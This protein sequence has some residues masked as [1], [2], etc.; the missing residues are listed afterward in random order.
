MTKLQ[1]KVAIITGAGSGLGREGALLFASEGAK[2]VVADFNVQSAIAVVNEIHESCG[3]AISVQVDVSQRSSV[4]NM[5]K[6]AIEFFGKIDILINNAGIIMDSRFHKMSQDQWQRV[7]DVNLTGVFNCTHAVIPYMLEK[8]YGK[9]VNTSSIIGTSG[10][11]GQVNYS[12]TKAGVIGITKSITKEYASKGINCNAVAFGF[13][14]SPMT[15]SMPEKVLKMMEE[16]V[17]AKRLGT[18]KDAAYAYLT[19]VLDENSYVNGTV[20]ECDGG[21]AI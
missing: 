3:T 18:P 15:A 1:G 4:D 16:K 10:G 20:L 13:M 9:I 17:P 12:A 2:V 19:L 7:I 14:Q 21:L 5:V 11:F 6:R 8:E